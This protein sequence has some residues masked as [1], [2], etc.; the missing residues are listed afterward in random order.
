MYR[1]AVTVCGVVFQM[2]TFPIAPRRNRKRHGDL[3]GLLNAQDG[4]EASDDK[5]L[6]RV[7]ARLDAVQ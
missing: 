2:P 1:N 5:R 4:R 6:E 3:S 7:M